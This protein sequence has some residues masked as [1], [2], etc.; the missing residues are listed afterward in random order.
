M[1]TELVV[2]LVQL[3]STG[4]LAFVLYFGLQANARMLEILADALSKCM[5]KQRELENEMH[6]L[7]GVASGQEETD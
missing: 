4:L 2:Q 7:H 3:G 1:S 5:D 6:E